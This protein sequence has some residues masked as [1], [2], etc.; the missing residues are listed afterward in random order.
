MCEVCDECYN[1]A[2]YL[3]DYWNCT[4]DGE[5]CHEYIPNKRDAEERKEGL[6]E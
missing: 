5:P 3:D 2:Y 6:E 1:C 4:G